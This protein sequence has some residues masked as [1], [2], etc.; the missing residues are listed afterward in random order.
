MKYK[1][2]KGFTMMEIMVLLFIIGIL[3]ALIGP[4]VAKYF[5]AAQE[6]EIKLKMSN[7][8]AALMSYRMEFGSFPSTRDGLR[9]L[10]ENLHTN[11]EQFKRAERAGKWPFL[12]GGEKSI[13]D[14]SGIDFIYNCPPEKYKNKYRSYE[15]MWIGKGSEDEPELDDGM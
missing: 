13:T 2:N 9:S 12:S 7:I 8:Q 11:D 4:R 6:T 15:I 14:S 10:L 5:R 1:L 3:M